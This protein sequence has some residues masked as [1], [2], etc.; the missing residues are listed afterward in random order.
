MLVTK[1]YASGTYL[2][3]MFIKSVIMFSMVNENKKK[4]LSLN[5]DLFGL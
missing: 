2:L 4:E 3:Y 1:Q 5:K